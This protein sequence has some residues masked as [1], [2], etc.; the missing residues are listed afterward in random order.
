MVFSASVCVVVVCSSV[1]SVVVE[2][3]SSRLA[4]AVTGL[5]PVRVSVSVVTVGSRSVVVVLTTEQVCA[6]SVVV[7]F[8]NVVLVNVHL[9]VVVVRRLATD[10]VFVLCSSPPPAY[11]VFQSV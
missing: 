8:S 9:V 1:S 10:V 11:T 4:V 6:P 2:T 3:L 7:P 5:S